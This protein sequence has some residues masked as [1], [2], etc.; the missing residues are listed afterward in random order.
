MEDWLVNMGDWCISRKRY[1]GLPLP[2]YFCEHGHMTVIGSQ[3]ELEERALRGTEALEE[4]HRPWIDEVVIR[5]GECDAEAYRL[6]DVGDCW[7]DAGIV[8]FATLGW[9]NET[10]VEAGYAAGAGVGVTIA[11]LPDHA[12]WERWYPADW[13]SEMREQIRLWF[14]SILFMGVVLDGRS[15]YRKVLTY[16]KV[17]DETGR[18][19]HK[20]WGNAIWFHEAI[21]DMGADVMRW[22]YAGQQPAQ[23]LNFGYGPA[24]EVKGRLLKLW[25]TYSFFV[26]Y[27]NIEGFEPRYE[28]LE[29]G[30]DPA[31]ARPLDRWLA[32]RTQWL[33][34][35][36]RAALDGWDSPRL[37]RAFETFLDDL[38]NWYVRLSRTRFWRS[39][40]PADS[41]AAF[42]T[43]WYALVQAIRCVSPVM[44]FLADEMWQNL[45]RGVCP[46]APHGV[47]LA[48]YPEV[49]D[50]LADAG[51]LAAMDTVRAVVELGRRSR[52]EARIKL[53]QPLREVIV[54]TDDPARRGQVADHVELIAA[55][56][57]VKAVRL[58]TSAEEFA[59][60][61]VM[62]LLKVLGP[63][64]GRDLAVIR[65]LLRE[66]EF[67]L[68]DGRVHVGDWTLEP[69]E[70]E[71]RARAREGFAVTDGEG[72]AVALDTEI[73]P[74][75]QLEGV[76]RDVIRTLQKM[77][78][79]AGFEV[80]DR[81]RVTYP[82]SDGDV[83]RAF[84][85]HGDWIAAETLAV[86][87]EPGEELAVARA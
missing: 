62:P 34:G 46:D 86:A 23:N 2:F 67:E 77:R 72:F 1:W 21:E 11:D 68:R 48:G 73:T 78:Q 87:L 32:A 59:Q 80:T 55:E 12:H 14:Y 85:E 82:R 35:E 84:A 38:S 60:V 75:L 6:P 54:A 13:V 64:Y 44:P 29:T 15:P 25:N 19:M 28:L 31:T 27:A 61:E 76:V 5:C 3:S 8:P 74:E 71:L 65:G 20:S 22:M 4:L 50:E 24:G 26:L 16:E 83:G 69:G 41:R 43:L 33:V 36:C 39:D 9:H 37:V 66:G 81:I 17:N 57:G 53:R 63:K 49:R 45:V 70:F 51:L 10:F 47:H 56:L 52:D 18:P 40:D 42:E 7:L 79:D 30:P 58:A